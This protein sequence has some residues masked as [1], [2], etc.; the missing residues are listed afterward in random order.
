MIMGSDMCSIDGDDGS[1]DDDG[2]DHPPLPSR[3]NHKNVN[4]FH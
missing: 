1:S 4:S 3:T 2:D